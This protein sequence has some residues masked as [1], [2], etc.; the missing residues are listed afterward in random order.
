MCTICFPDD[1]K[2]QKMVKVPCNGGLGV[3]VKQHVS[4]KKRTLNPVHLQDQQ[5]ILTIEPSF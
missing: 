5:V 4:A 2:G 3:A 1:H